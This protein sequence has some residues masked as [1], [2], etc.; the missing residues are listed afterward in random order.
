MEIFI[1]KHC[2]WAR[3]RLARLQHAATVFDDSLNIRAAVPRALYEWVPSHV[4]VCG[5]EI[6]E[7][8]SHKDSALGGCLTFS[9]IAT[10]VNQEIS[11]IWRQALVHE[12]YGGN[13]FGAALLGTSSRRNE[14][15]LPRLRSGHT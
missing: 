12:W 5:K 8:G 9:E 1:A 15:I 6:E 3:I 11:S 13:R 10:R 14:I 4:N 7:K 2:H